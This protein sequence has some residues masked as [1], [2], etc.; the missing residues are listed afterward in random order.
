MRAS[1][2]GNSTLALRG[3]KQFQNSNKHKFVSKWTSSLQCWGS[4]QPHCHC[5]LDLLTNELVSCCVGNREY[6]ENTRKQEVVKKGKVA[7]VVVV[8]KCCK[9]NKKNN[10]NELVFWR[11]DWLLNGGRMDD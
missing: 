11:F 3:E 6:V 4:R 1:L 5:W 9:I 2:I 7:H 8:T 10:N